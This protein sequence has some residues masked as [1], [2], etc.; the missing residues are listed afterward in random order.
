MQALPSQQSGYVAQLKH[1]LLTKLQ[2]YGDEKL[3]DIVVTNIT[4]LY[5]AIFK[6]DIE[7]VKLLLS[8]KITDLPNHNPLNDSCILYYL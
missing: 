8:N 5:Y 7:L 2:G 3:N 6:E 4:V 1:D